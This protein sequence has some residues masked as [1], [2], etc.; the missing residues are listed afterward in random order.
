MLERAPFD[1][2]WVLAALERLHDAAFAFDREGRALWANGAATR[3]VGVEPDLLVGR[4][5]RDLPHPVSGASFAEAFRGVLADGETRRFACDVVDPPQRLLGEIA[6]GGG[7]LV[8]LFRTAP[9]LE[10][11]VWRSLFEQAPAHIALLAGPEHRFVFVNELG[12]A[13]VGGRTDLVGKSAH[14]A[15]PELDGSPLHEVLDGVFRTGVPWM[16]DEVLVPFAGRDGRPEERWFTFLYSPYR[17]GD[18]AIAGVM[19]FGFE[20]TTMVRARRR[21]E[22]LF[23]ANLIGTVFWRLD[24]LVF[25][26]NDAFLEMLGYSR[27]ELVAGRISLGDLSPPHGELRVR[28]AHD[29]YEKELVRRDGT[30]V[31]VLVSAARFPD[32]DEGVSCVV[33]LTAVKHAEARIRELLD[34]AQSAMRAKDEF[35]AMLGHELR[36]PLAP[37]ATALELLKLRGVQPPELQTVAR[38]VAHLGRLVDDLLDVARIARGDV[39]LEREPVSLDRVV[40]HAVEIAEP[41]IEARQ[42][43]LTIDVPLPAPIVVGDEARL[44]QA[45][46]NLLVNAA[47]YT[48]RGGGI[49]L[50]VARG[51]DGRAAIQVRDDGE[52]IPAELL[53]RIFELFVRGAG[54][55]QRDASGGLGL[56]LAI[57]RNLVELHGGEV[58]AYSDGVGRGS[59]FTI[60]LP[61]APAEVRP[62]EAFE[63]DAA[64]LLP[65][66][67]AARVLI[68]D[69]NVDAAE[70]LGELVAQH[71]YVV[72]VAHD[73]PEA[74][75]VAERFHPDVAVL[76]LGLPVMDGYE[77]GRR[78][79]EAHGPSLMLFALTG[80]GQPSDRAATQ[81]AG[82]SAHFVKPVAPEQLLAELAA[83]AAAAESTA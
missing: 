79:R 11:E 9:A 62:S 71:G 51:D 73:G 14:E 57:V 43:R 19:S 29:P 22:A 24:G 54:G 70:L 38:Q 25:D 48:A 82:F 34:E 83:V 41:I 4:G 8:A 13:A 12:R 67:G 28:G 6:D 5:Y 63:G 1:S 16:G 72:E 30:R 3:L 49:A 60:R 80:Y 47:R 76:D 69:D 56:G 53:P 18:G 39:R 58:E 26:A 55:V 46:S 52:G 45:V 37:I 15:F 21:I 7:A 33:D 23:D 78:L 10:S 59:R 32:S 65:S 74:L 77:L 64:G 40:A 81:R 75:R 17:D 42:H 20:V 44:A 31:P 61:I 68:V 50:A 2:A 36:N 35:L 66:R 27:E